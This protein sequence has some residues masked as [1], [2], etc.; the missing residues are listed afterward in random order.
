MSSPGLTDP[1]SVPT[2]ITDRLSFA[3]GTGGTDPM[4]SHP[5]DAVGGGSASPPATGGRRRALPLLVAVASL[6]LAGLVVADFGETPAPT[7]SSAPVVA[8]PESPSPPAEAEPAAPSTHVSPLVTANTASPPS[9]KPAIGPAATKKSKRVVRPRD[10]TPVRR[11]EAVSSPRPAAAAPS[12]EVPP[13]SAPESKGAATEPPKAA[14]APPTA[15]T[16]KPVGPSL[17]DDLANPYR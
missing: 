11:S 6:L 4:S 13:P 8:S 15:P 2:G 12:A 14:V 7:P 16:P 1:M 5:P 9:Q 10:Q 3:D 17:D